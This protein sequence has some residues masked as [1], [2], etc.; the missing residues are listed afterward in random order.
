VAS[1]ANSRVKA[2]NFQYEYGIDQSREDVR[3]FGNCKLFDD[4]IRP[5]S[6][7]L[8][9]G[10]FPGYHINDLPAE[11]EEFPYFTCLFCNWN[12]CTSTAEKI[13]TKLPGTGY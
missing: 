12:K 8:C 5:F 11:G 3:P 6:Q 13:C 10:I 4:R 2:S 7:G 9:Q 1:L